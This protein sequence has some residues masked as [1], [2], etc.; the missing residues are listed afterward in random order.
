MTIT[1]KK[2]FREWDVLVIKNNREKIETSY[3]FKDK[4]DAIKFIDGLMSSN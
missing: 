2:N 1:I 3:H 4:K